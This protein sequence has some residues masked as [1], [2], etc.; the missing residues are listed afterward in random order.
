M[1]D[2][3]SVRGRPIVKL[4]CSPSGRR[5]KLRARAKVSSKSSRFTIIEA[6][7]T[8]P[9]SA[10]SRI[11]VVTPRERPKSS[12][13]MISRRSLSV[14]ATRSVAPHAHQVREHLGSVLHEGDRARL[15]PIVKV[16]RGLL[17]FQAVAAGDIKAL[18][19]KSETVKR[20]PRENDLRCFGGEPL[21]A[22]LRVQNSGKQ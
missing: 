14:Y 9:A 18:E 4:R 12:A 19:I 5:P 2:G 13:F 20:E 11:P 3:A 22:G 15:V 1:R 7:V 8:A 10:A 6:E 17:D 16:H 21:Q